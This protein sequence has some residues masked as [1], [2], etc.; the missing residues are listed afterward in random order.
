[1]LSQQ[2]ADAVVTALRAASGTQPITIGG[3]GFGENNPVANNST[4]GG[5]Q[6]NRRVTIHVRPAA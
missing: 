6:Q 4:P 5:R 3:H 2:R 1:V